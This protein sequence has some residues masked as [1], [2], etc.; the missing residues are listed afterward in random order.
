MEAKLIL[1]TQKQY[2]QTRATRD[3]GMLKKLLET[4]VQKFLK[5]KML[6]TKHFIR[7]LRNRS[8]KL[9]LVKLASSSLKLM[10]L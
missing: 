9:I 6:F 3:V 7:I 10:L 8:L 4:F 5:E 1:E 2:F